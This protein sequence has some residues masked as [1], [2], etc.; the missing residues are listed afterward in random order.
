MGLPR[1]GKTSLIK[2][3]F[4]KLSPYDTHILSQDNQITNYRESNPPL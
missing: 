2:V 3:I 1:S 4:Q